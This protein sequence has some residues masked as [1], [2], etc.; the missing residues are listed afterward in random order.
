[1]G[2]IECAES[3][4]CSAV[5]FPDPKYH[6]AGNHEPEDHDAEADPEQVVPGQFPIVGGGTC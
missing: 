3:G 1:M 5:R 6:A 4:H 2:G